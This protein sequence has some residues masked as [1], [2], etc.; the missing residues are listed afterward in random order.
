M[1]LHRLVEQF[2]ER[3]RRAASAAE[4]FDMASAAAI[5][6]GFPKL[7]LVHGEWF[8]RPSPALIR[9]DN[10]GEWADIFVERRYYQ[11]DPVLLASQRSNIAFSWARLSEIIPITPRQCLILTEAERHGLRCGFTMPVGVV[12]EPSG[13]CSFA[14]DVAQLPAR[15]SCRAAGII[16]AEAFN[17]ARRLHGY[18]ARRRDVPRLSPRK[19]ECLRWLSCGKT[20]GEIAIILGLREPTVRT[21]MT[22]LRKDFEVVSRCQLVAEALRFG[23][24]SY[25]DAIPSF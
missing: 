4:L 3:A 17:A 20:D 1:A 19:L 16:G 12:G 22:L 2:S 8:R 23:L 13:C 6:L 25:D 24:I 9:L 18:P 14:S 7:A 15:W 11:E 21:Y 10:F 5:E